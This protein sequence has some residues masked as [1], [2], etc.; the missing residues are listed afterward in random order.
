MKEFLEMWN[1]VFHG[2]PPANE[3]IFWIVEC[4]LGDLIC[5]GVLII[6]VIVGFYLYIRYL[7]WI[8]IEKPD[9]AFQLRDAI[10]EQT[11]DFSVYDMSDE[12]LEALHESECDF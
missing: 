2:E 12:E 9:R 3:T 7:D 4:G 1:G 8:Y 6:P 11:G 10:V 5:F